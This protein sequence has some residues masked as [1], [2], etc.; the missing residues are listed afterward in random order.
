MPKL[1]VSPMK[2]VSLAREVRQAVEGPAR[3]LVM[4]TNAVAVESVRS[5]LVGES[6][7]EA[8]GGGRSPVESIVLEERGAFPKAAFS[9][10][11]AVDIVVASMEELSA[12]GLKEHLAELARKDKPVVVVLEEAP[13]VEISFPGVGADR[14]VGMSMDGSA[15]AD[16]L[17]E[18]VVDA[19]GDA[20]VALAARL[21]SLRDEVCRQIVRKTSRQNAV[22]GCLF[23]LPGADMPVMTINE[24]RMVLRLAAAHGEEV[25]AERALELLG[26]VGAGFGLRAIARQALD[27]LPGPGWVIKGAVAYTGTR[28]LGRAARAY[29]DSP[30]RLTPSRLEPLVEKIKRLRG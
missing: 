4:G 27:L 26:V 8:A 13:G 7:L 24:A 9:D 15:P 12:N 18:A 30:Q 6:W 1:P 21:P 10:L 22:I 19:A 17:A 3:T 25:G 20:A 5:A 29:F 16:V 14:V 11:V 28:A 23:V 2:V